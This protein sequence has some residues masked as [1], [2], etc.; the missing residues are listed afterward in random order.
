MSSCLDEFIL[1]KPERVAIRAI[2]AISDPVS[3]RNS[4]NSHVPESLQNKINTAEL[5]GFRHAYRFKLR[6]GEGGGTYLTEE[7]DL[8]IARQE[9]VKRYG[10]RLLLVSKMRSQ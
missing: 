2:P 6:D 8:N 5:S 3:S 9:L 7:S 10:D 4:A 1:Y